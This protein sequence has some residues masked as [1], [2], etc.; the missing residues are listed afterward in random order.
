M[1]SFTATE[2]QSIAQSVVRNFSQKV[3]RPAARQADEDCK[4]DKAALQGAW[5]L[6]LVQAIAGA[7]DG[8]PEQATLLNTLLLEELADGDAAVAVAIAASLGFAKAIAEQGSNNQKRALL[9]FF[10][11]RTPSPAAIALVDASHPGT[12]AAKTQ[13]GYKI[14]GV[15]AM[16]ARAGLHSFPRRGAMRRQAGCVHRAAGGSQ[17]PPK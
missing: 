10:A 4:L 16:I 11:G 15:K 12:T 2:E 9:P 14:S 3:L 8:L 5:D 13:G 1:I 17:Y 6:E 7:Q